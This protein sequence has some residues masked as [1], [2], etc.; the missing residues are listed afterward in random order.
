MMTPNF[1][2]STPTQMVVSHVME[3]L[4][5]LTLEDLC[6]ACAA[7]ADIIIELVDEGVVVPLGQTPDLWRFTGLHLQHAKI[8][9]R[10]HRDLRVNFAGAALVLQ[11]MEELEVLRGQMNDGQA[12]QPG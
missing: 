6:R 4:S 12:R 8:A 7:Q 1:I 11:L 9:M 3:D 2:L 5:D 10:L